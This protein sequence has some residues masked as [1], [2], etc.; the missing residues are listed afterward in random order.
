[1]DRRTFL[2][3]TTVTAGSGAASYKHLRAHQTVLN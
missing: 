2:K 1:M 3:A